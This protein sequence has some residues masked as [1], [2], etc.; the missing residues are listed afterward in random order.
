ML[1]VAVIIIA[2]LANF[3][4]FK[5]RGLPPVPPEIYGTL[6]GILFL[7]AA[8]YKKFWFAL[9]LFGVAIVYLLLLVIN[10]YNL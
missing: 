10:I 5:G 6:H 4:L 8:T 1:T 2:H 3:T 9:A 7:L